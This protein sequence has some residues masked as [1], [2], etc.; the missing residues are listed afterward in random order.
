[1]AQVDK[2]VL[3]EHPSHAMYCLVDGVEDY[4]QFL[5]W[6]GGTEVKRRDDNTTIAT[7]YINYMGIKQSF[8]TENNKL[9]HKEMNISLK[10]GPFT[11]LQGHWRFHS[12]SDSACKIEFSLNYTF[13]STVLEKIL[14]PVFNHIA[15][16]FVDAFVA[17]ADKLYGP[18]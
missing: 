16:T 7:I 4:P 17:R 5:P 18:S 10:E 6:C 3:V 15:N 1:M 11:H 8:T 9:P 2:S 13:S 14:T 12:L